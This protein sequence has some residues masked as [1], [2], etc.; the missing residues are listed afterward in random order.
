MSFPLVN[1]YRRTWD[2]L[3]HD[4]VIRYLRT[5]GINLDAYADDLQCCDCTDEEIPMKVKATV[6]ELRA[7]ANTL[8]GLL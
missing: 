6:A 1:D 3:Q 5:M 8:E 7:V 4:T 2:A